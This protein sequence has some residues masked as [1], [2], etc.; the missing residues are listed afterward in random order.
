L[1]STPDRKADTLAHWL[2]AHPGVTVI[3]RDRAPA[4]ADGARRGAPT[5]IQ[6]AD[7]FHLV[8]NLQEHL[9]TMFERKNACLL[10]PLPGTPS[11]QLLSQNQLATQP[12]AEAETEKELLQT[13]QTPISTPT[14]SQSINRKEYYFEQI[15]MLAEAGLTQR[16]IARELKISRQSVK[17]YLN[18][19]TVPR[20]TPRAARPSKLDPYK[21]YLAARW[22][23]GVTKTLTLFREI[24]ERGYEGSWGLLA[25]YLVKYRQEHPVPKP[26]QPTVGRPSGSGS[27]RTAKGY[28][29]QEP[30]PKVQPLLSASQAAFILLKDP[31]DL[32]EKQHD[33]L[34]HLRAFD[35]EIQ[36]A[37]ALTQ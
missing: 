32:S 19:S 28:G 23:Q 29:V 34:N 26:A 5:V 20:Y 10:V 24:E 33:L 1:N 36:A 21:P 12:Q 4:Y 27:S 35:T 25:G 16:G 22:E 37:Y 15:K 13:A 18:A 7:R 31:A 2:Q 8:K 9:K 30:I 17:K 14:T 6:V 3:S 11:Q